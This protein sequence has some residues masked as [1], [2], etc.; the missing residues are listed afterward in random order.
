MLLVFVLVFL[1]LPFAELYVIFQ[2]GHAIGIL[3]T[4]AVMMII[5]MVGAWLA[6]SEGFFVVRRLQDCLAEGRAP[7]DEMLDGALVLAGALLLLTPGFVTDAAGLLLLFPPSRAV[8]R[9]Y[10]RRK[11]RVR[12]ASPGHR[13]R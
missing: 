4:L 1:A 7:A 10:A 3:D 11:L 6:R 2:V 12:V 5:S 9:A 13:R 8:A